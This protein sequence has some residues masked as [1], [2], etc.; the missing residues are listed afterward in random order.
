M[1]FSGQI[2]LDRSSSKPIYLQIAE[3]IAE[4][5]RDGSIPP[6]TALPPVPALCA[7]AGGVNH[8]TVRQGIAHLVK[9]GT[10]FG[11]KGKGVFVAERSETTQRARGT[12][13][14]V[15][16]ALDQGFAHRIVLG[17][18]KSLRKAGYDLVLCNSDYSSS[19]EVDHLRRVHDA[20]VDGVL[21]MPFMPPANKEV[22]R[23]LIDD[24]ARPMPVVC[25]DRGFK[26]PAIPMVGVDNYKA[27]YDAVSYLIS[28]GHRRI[29]FVVNALSLIKQIEAID[30]RFQGYR[31]ALEDQGI[32]FDAE[33]VQEIG[34]SLAM[35]KPEEVG[36]DHYGYQ[37]MHKLLM[38]KDRPTAVFLL[39]D[40]LAPGAVAAIQNHGLSV[41]NDI[42][43]V[44]FNDDMLAR[45][46]SPPLTTVAQPA[47]QIGVEAA[48]L[49]I[50]LIEKSP[51][52]VPRVALA[53][54]L[55]SRGTTAVY[56]SSPL[57]GDAF[58]LTKV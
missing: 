19:R 4:R 25:V 23:S 14:F 50:K 48:S 22:I 35:M 49:V 5:I 47:E 12:V 27:A 43:L 42:S 18:E 54:R 44:G 37:A 51:V 40:E 52:D 13:A 39:W 30:M 28:L 57:V 20:G 8:L 3:W 56:G 58:A 7:Q 17:A 2:P 31:R 55:V 45:L 36:L 34:P 26:D 32:S 53:T 46:M 21:L 11:V 41:P 6:G 9:A 38:L 1:N 24:K 29:G 16:S 15:C 33:L 10:L